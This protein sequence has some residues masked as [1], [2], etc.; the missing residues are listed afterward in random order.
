MKLPHT[1]IFHILTRIS[2]AESLISN[3]NMF[4]L[5]LSAHTLMIFPNVGVSA[6]ISEWKLPIVAPQRDR[7]HLSQQSVTVP[8]EWPQP[9]RPINMRD[10]AGEQL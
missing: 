8:L 6:S 5:I 7:K 10:Y 9:H 2:S 1:H 4:L 3:H